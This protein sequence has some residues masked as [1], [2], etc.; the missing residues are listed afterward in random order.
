MQR[1]RTERKLM[2]TVKQQFGPGRPADEQGIAFEGLYKGLQLLIEADSRG[3]YTV[4]A[5]DRTTC[6]LASY[7]IERADVARTMQNHLKEPGIIGY[8]GGE[9]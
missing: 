9:A 1:F 4:S 3:L 7:G 5:W 2:N 8:V 6:W